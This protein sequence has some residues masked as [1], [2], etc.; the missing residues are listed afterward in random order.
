MTNTSALSGSRIRSIDAGKIRREKIKRELI[1]DFVEMI[2]Q[3]TT[4]ER[5]TSSAKIPS[6][7]LRYI[8]PN[9]GSNCA[10][11][12]SHANHCAND[13]SVKDE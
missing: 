12:N 9:D 10:L 6:P 3:C 1:D 13:A 5:T 2:K 8:T 7:G 11:D 4:R